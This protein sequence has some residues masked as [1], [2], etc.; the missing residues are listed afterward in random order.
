[1]LEYAYRQTGAR[2][3]A[4]GGHLWMGNGAD[5]EVPRT[6][7]TW[8]ESDCH[9]SPLR[10]EDDIHHDV[11]RDVFFPYDHHIVG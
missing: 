5:I 10:A 1:M 6:V 9:L 7:V 8:T 11:E 2:R 3:G 4:G